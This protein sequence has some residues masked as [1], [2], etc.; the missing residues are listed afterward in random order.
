MWAT[1]TFLQRYIYIHGTLSNFI[2]YIANT[3]LSRPFKSTVEVAGPPSATL[4][5]IR[6][7]QLSV[8]RTSSIRHH[9]LNFFFI[10]RVCNS[11]V[12]VYNRCCTS[13][14][15]A[16]LVNEDNI[17]WLLDMLKND[18]FRG[19]EKVTKDQFMDV[20]GDSQD[21]NAF[22]KV[23]SQIAVEKFNMKEVFDMRSSVR[24]AAIEKLCE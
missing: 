12:C 11:F 1:V 8:V 13:N 7:K 2:V 14:C 15:N 16:G 18:I 6:P 5:T 3:S 4:H 9:A 10:E 19:C 24:L 17:P 22:W 20:R 23:V 21:K